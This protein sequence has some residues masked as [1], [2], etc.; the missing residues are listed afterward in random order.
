MAAREGVRSCPESHPDSRFRRRWCGHAGWLLPEPGT[1]LPLL[2]SR[3]CWNRHLKLGDKRQIYCPAPEA[4]S[5]KSRCHR[6]RFL[7]RQ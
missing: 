7:P 5:W 4:R 6:G 1:Q 2:V 3:G